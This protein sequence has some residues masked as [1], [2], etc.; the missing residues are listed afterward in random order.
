MQIMPNHAKDSLRNAIEHSCLL[1]MK[2][3][4]MTNKL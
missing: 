1:L 3:D 4:I 2:L